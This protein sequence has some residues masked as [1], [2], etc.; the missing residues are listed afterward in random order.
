MTRKNP[1]AGNHAHRREGEQRRAEFLKY[2]GQGYTLRECCTLVGVK[3]ATYSRWRMRHPEFRLAVDA[4]RN[5]IEETTYDGTEPEFVRKYFGMVPADFQ[6]DF[7]ERINQLRQGDILMA[8]WPPEHG[9]TTTFENHAS[10]ELAENPEMRFTVGS[11]SAKI[12]RKIVGRVRNRMEPDGSAQEYVRD[13]GPFVPQTGV[14]R[15]PAQPWNDSM[16]NVYKKS[17][18]DERD[19]SMIAIGRDSSI[20]STRTDHLHIDDVQ[21]TKT[22]NLTPKLIEWFR[23]DALSR[24]GEHGIITIAGTRVCPDDFYETLED[25]PDLVGILHTV[26]YPA[27]VTD[28]ETGEE[29]P[30]LP[31][32]YTME[33]LDR[34]RRKVGQEAWDRNYMQQPGASGADRVFDDEAIEKSLDRELSLLHALPP[35]GVVYVGLD[36]ALGGKNCVMA[37]HVRADNALQIAWINEKENLRTNEQIMDELGQTVMRMRAMD[38]RVTD[39]VIETMNFQKGLGRDERLIQLQR[40]YGFRIREHLTGWNKYDEDIGIASMA[41][42]FRLGEIV[43]PFADDP[44]TQ[45]EIGEL[46]RQLK[47]WR[48]GHRGSRKRQDR[49]MALWFCWILWQQRHKRRPEEDSHDGWRRQGL[50]WKRTEVGLILPSRVKVSA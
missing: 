10:K 46:V 2:L 47:S 33:N 7:I 24:P 8:L 41:M 20:V 44:T 25:D 40:E 22:K 37:T 11:E 18:H 31:Q 3:Q 28:Q 30:L 4:L 48:H 12:S 38:V 1:N 29:R 43:L 16:F 5:G 17:T 36:P 32:R 35:D 39:V 26:R 9:K 6:I 27:I 14:G 13:F 45:R 19:Y 50:P 23:Q 42:S 21:S 34:M 49:L 15:K